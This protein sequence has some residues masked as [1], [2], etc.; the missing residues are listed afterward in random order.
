MA[1]LDQWAAEAY[2]PKFPVVLSR[3]APLALGSSYFLAACS[4]TREYTL[5][6]T[7]RAPGIDG[8][9]RIEEIDGGNHLVTV[10][11]TN[12]VPPN[13][14]SSGLTTY[15]VWFCGP[16]APTKAGALAY[17]EDNREGSL[18]ATTPYTDF[19]LRITV[20]NSPS[21]ASPSDVLVVRRR[22]TG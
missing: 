11:M 13:R 16:G 19:E 18:F 21:V 15:V 10:S 1:L 5:L 3:L 12:L 17:D 8:M 20:E 6:G 7:E 22:V 14:L 4:G 2:K 9:V